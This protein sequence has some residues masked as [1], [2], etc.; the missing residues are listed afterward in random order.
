MVDAQQR[1]TGRVPYTIDVT[2][3]GMHQARILRSNRA[4]ARIRRIDVSRARGVPGVPP[5]LPGAAILA[6]ARLFPY[7][8]PVLRDQPI[9]A[10]DKVRYAGEPVVAVAAIDGDAAQEALD[11]VEIEY[12]DLPAVFD[13]DAALAADAPLLH[14]GPP[15][16][17]R[18]YADVIVHPG[19]GTNV[20]NHFKVRK[21]DVERGFAEAAHVFEDVFT[22]PPAST[23]PLET[24]A[25]VADVRD[26]RITIW[27]NA[28]A[29]FATRATLAEVF[30]LPQ[31]D[32][33]VIVPTLGGG[34]GSKGYPKIEP[35][36]AVLSYFARRP[37]RLHLTREEEFLTITKHGVR[38]ELRTGLSADGQILAKQARCL[39]NTGA[40]ADIGP[41]LV[42]NGGFGVGGP[43]NI[44]N[45]WVDSYA[46]Y[47]NI[48]P[49]G[50]FRGYG[51]NQA[52]WAYETQLDMIAE[53][54]G[55]DPLELRVRNL[56]VDGEADMVGAPVHDAR[57]RELLDHAATWIGWDP[58]ERPERRGSR[59]RAKGVSCIL[60]GTITPST[61]SAI[62]R[63]DDDGSLHV[64]TSSVEMGQGLLM[65]LAIMAAEGLSMPV[66]RVRVSTPDTDLTPYDQVTGSSRSTHSMGTA[67]GRAVA[68]IREQ[69][70]ALAA[71]ELEIGAGDL[72]LADGMVRPKDAPDRG[73][74][75]GDVLRAAQTSC[76]IGRATFRTEGGLDPE[77]GLG[78]ASVHWHQAA[79]AAEV[80]VDLETGSVDVLRYHAGVYAARIINPVQAELQTEGNVAFGVG[81]AFLEE[82]TFDGGQLQ[83][84]NLA[85]YMI[86]AVE[87][88]PREIHLDIVE[89]REVNDVHGIG[90]TSMPPVSPAIGNAVFRA[91]GVRIRDLPITPEKIL[92]GLRALPDSPAS[93]DS[94]IP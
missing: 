83:N 57:F 4:H 46:I 44:P 31:A 84:G 35:L 10:L 86:P 27:A 26:G 69:L 66:G 53:R 14:E 52:A 77:T 75:L 64:L 29:P 88:L 32:V 17:G 2:L 9:L 45:F 37:V 43:Y 93:R 15:R 13:V 23:V 39:F 76:L 71:D 58:G 3:P 92:R 7:Y 42:K 65:T 68:E 59:V 48:V 72:E 61:S 1:A 85:D 25:A 30:G 38:I 40:Y 89:H 78:I 16:M 81:Q 82:M 94:R 74:G 11:L 12:E 21:G 49:A 6:E 55:I 36:T 90:E 47:T 80:E 18:T 22:T 33:R 41:R 70:L 20:C 54:L 8:G 63:L 91:T 60:K 51:I 24:H 56:L 34:Y 87:D 19:E 62:A 50:A 67:V 5:V 28:Q 79:G 73:V